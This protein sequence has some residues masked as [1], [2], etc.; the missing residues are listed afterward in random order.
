MFDTKAI[1]NRISP[2]DY[3]LDAL[4]PEYGKFDTVAVAEQAR[5]FKAL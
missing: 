5:N 1:K 3:F 2:R 4:V